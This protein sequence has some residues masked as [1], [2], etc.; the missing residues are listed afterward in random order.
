MHT[1]FWSGNFKGK[2]KYVT[3]GSKTAV[4]DVIGFMCISLGSSTVQLYDSLGTRRACA[5]SGDGFGSQ[6]DGR[7]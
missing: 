3:N 7:A 6:N 5:C 2:H 1:V 4:V